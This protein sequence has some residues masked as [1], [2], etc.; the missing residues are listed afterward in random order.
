[1][2]HENGPFYNNESSLRLKAVRK[3]I[4]RGLSL[5]LDDRRPLK[6][7]KVREN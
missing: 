2:S 1:M 5:K 6:K 3:N 4:W 7:K